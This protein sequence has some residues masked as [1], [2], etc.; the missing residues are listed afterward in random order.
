MELLHITYKK[1]RFVTHEDQSFSYLTSTGSFSKLVN[2]L[3]VFIGN[4]GA[5]AENKNDFFS[6]VLEVM[7]TVMFLSQEG[8]DRSVKYLN[9]NNGSVQS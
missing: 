1:L 9:E 8:M 2:Y 3:T 4:R 6:D 5:I 7:P